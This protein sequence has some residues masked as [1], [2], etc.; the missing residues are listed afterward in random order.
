MKRSLYRIT[1]K[2]FIPSDLIF[3]ILIEDQTTKKFKNQLFFLS[4][5]EFISLRTIMTDLPRRASSFLDVFK[6]NPNSVTPLNRIFDNPYIKHLREKGLFYII[7]KSYV[8]II[9]F[10]NLNY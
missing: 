7:K 6:F 8:S 1:N 3:E 4:M 5:T 9:S 2:S 10:Q